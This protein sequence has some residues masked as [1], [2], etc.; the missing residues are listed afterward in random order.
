MLQVGHIFRF[1]PVTTCVARADRE[2]RALGACATARVVSRVQAPAHR[3]GR[4]ADRRHPLLRPVRPSARAGRP[5]RSPPRC[6]IT[7]AAGWT[8]ARSPPWS[9]ATSPRSWKPA[10]SRPGTYRDCVIVGEQGTLAGDFGTAEVACSPTPRRGAA[11]GRRPRAR[12]RPSRPRVPSR[13]ATSSSCS[14]TRSRDGR[15]RS[16]WRRDCSPCRLSK[17]PS[18][19]RRWAAR[20]A[21]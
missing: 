19:P 10:T 8:I 3:R 5:P 13:F 1:H 18:A 4:D 14:W 16:T 11:A 12:C 17:P 21:R 20:H 7:S 9:T 15:R 2:R 6:A